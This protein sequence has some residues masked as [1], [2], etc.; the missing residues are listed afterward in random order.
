[1]KNNGFFISTGFK[2]GFYTLKQLVFE[3]RYAQGC[4]GQWVAA[5]CDQKE[6]FYQN[7]STDRDEALRKAKELTGYD[8][9]INFDLDEIERLKAEEYARIRAE[10]Q[11]A[12]EATDWSV[13]QFGKFEGRSVADVFSEN[14]G[15]VEWFANAWVNESDAGKLRTRQFCR[16]IVAP[17][18]A[19][20]QSRESSEAQAIVDALGADAVRDIAAGG[21]DGFAKSVCSQLLSGSAPSP[22][23]VH[24]LVEIFAKRAGRRNSRA[25]S[26]AFAAIVERLPEYKQA[27]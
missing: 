9:N 2:N 7:L 13:F 5:G 15:Y 27:A 19:A 22:R 18:V 24:I 26:A 10:K 1:M 17:V 6:V 14:P 20:R 8:L 3:T 4:S 11:A 23:A 12:F 25:Y 16:D 21:A